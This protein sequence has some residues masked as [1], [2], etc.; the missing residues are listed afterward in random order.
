MVYLGDDFSDTP[1]D[2]RPEH[3]FTKERVEVGTVAGQKWMSRLQLATHERLAELEKGR[4]EA[5]VILKATEAVIERSE[6]RGDWKVGLIDTYLG[7]DNRILGLYVHQLPPDSFTET[8]KHGEAIVYVLSGSGYSIVEGQRY[9]WRA[10][11]CIFVQP[12]M[13]HQH[14][15]NDPEQVSQ[16]IAIMSAPLRD[17]IVRGAE[18]VDWKTE[19]DLAEQAARAASA[20]PGQ[21]WA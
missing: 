5:R 6:H 16:H 13:W 21:W 17:R 10:G 1:D 7:F 20:D 3:P 8:H 9:E 15:N 4:R 11:D 2:Y 12:G 19:A 18:Y 14:F